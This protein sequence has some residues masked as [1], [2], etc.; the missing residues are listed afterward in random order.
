MTKTEAGPLPHWIPKYELKTDH[1]L[2]WKNYSY[3][4]H[5]IPLHT[6]SDGCHEEDRREQVLARTW[7]PSI[8][9]PRQW[10]VCKLMQP[11]WRTVWPVL[12]MVN[13]EVPRDPATALSSILP[14]EM[15]PRV[16]PK[17]GPERSQ[18]H[19]T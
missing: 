8:H 9:P 10:G 12:T 1:R 2:K 15:K 11:L 14:R 7:K 3:K 4:S 6:S 19:Y 5:G 17:D 18:E 13:M 16:H